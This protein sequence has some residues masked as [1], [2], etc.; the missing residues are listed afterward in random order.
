MLT[1][2][3]VEIL[4]CI[5]EHISTNCYPPTHREIADRVGISSLSV[6]NYNLAALEAKGYI[7]RDQCVARGIRVL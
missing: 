4:D 1:P 6:V 5:K 2:R 7:E 3:Q